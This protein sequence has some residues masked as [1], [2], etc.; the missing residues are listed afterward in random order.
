MS[1]KLLLKLDS[2]GFILSNHTSAHFAFLDHP[3]NSRNR[4]LFYSTLA[5]L[6]FMEDMPARFKAFI[7]P[8]QQVGA[9]AVVFGPGGWGC[10]VSMVQWERDGW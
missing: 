4:T 10:R 9:G 2:T 5:R 8:L 6:L 7:T 1:G 3:T